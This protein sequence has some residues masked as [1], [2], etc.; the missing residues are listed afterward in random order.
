MSCKPIGNL[1]SFIIG[2]I[3]VS[4]SGS[5]ALQLS[6]N[7][8]CNTR[9]HTRAQCARENSLKTRENLSAIWIISSC[10]RRCSSYATMLGSRGNFLIFCH[11][12]LL[13][14]RVWWWDFVWFSLCV[15]TH[16]HR[17]YE[18]HCTTHRPA[19]TDRL[20]RV[21]QDH[22]SF[23]FHGWVLP[24]SSDFWGVWKG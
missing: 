7:V 24:S 23:T 16:T 13:Y 14:F 11:C 20:R 17:K 15:K 3:S 9:T 19:L 8:W 21:F 5:R 4:L 12:H 1:I 10:H 6:H 22:D 18:F 2:N